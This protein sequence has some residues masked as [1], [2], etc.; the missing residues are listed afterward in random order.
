LTAFGEIAIA[1]LN[2]HRNFFGERLSIA[3][4]GQ[5]AFTSC[6]GFGLERWLWA[7]ER[8]AAPP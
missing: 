6:V 8:V 7:R 5:P 4:D 2:L 1:S 3:F